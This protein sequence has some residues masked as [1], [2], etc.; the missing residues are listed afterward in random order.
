MATQICRSGR[1]DV[2]QT[3]GVGWL[4]R[5]DDRNQRRADATTCGSLRNRDDEDTGPVEIASSHLSLSGGLVGIVAAVV[6]LVA[7]L[8]RLRRRP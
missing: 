2:V 1:S 3:G 4:R 6:A 5:M 7:G 8:V